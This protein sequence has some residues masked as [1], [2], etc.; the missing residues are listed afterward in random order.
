MNDC[1]GNESSQS[2]TEEDRRGDLGNSSNTAQLKMDFVAWAHISK[3]DG[4]YFSLK[5]PNIQK[6]GYLN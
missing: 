2:V 5:K 4:L 6:K 3:P 1:V